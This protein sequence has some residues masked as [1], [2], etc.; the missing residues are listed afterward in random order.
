VGIFG[1]R[2]CPAVPDPGTREGLSEA[3][4]LALPPRFEAVGEALVAGCGSVEA[5]EVVGSD[6]ARDGVPLAEALD[7]L[8]T[9]YRM[10]RGGD[11]DHA[12]TRALSLGWSEATLGY[13]NRLS[14]EDPLTG[15][16]S[17]A[18]VRSRLS[19]LY[20]G[21]PRLD[22]CHRGGTRDTHALVVIDVPV[23]R[24]S[25]HAGRT[26]VEQ[27][28]RASR[29]G[30]LAR[31]A[32]P[33]TETVARVGPRKVVV[34]CGRDEWLGLRV[35]ELRQRLAGLESGVAP[36]RVWIEALPDRDAEA[37]SLLDDLAQ[38]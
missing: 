4:R 24:G 36:A 27:A 26:R 15:L 12:D 17:M 38:A 13:L 22:P 9:T 19:E 1:I 37:A 21:D 35:A 2:G 3:I 23:A 30:A 29:V 18:H 7:A 28:L 5:C 10:V 14:C 34:L 16:A 11:P 31:A 25:A 8:S 20:R 33:G 6:L 32:F